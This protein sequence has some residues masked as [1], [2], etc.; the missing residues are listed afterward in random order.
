MKFQILSKVNY[1]LYSDIERTACVKKLLS[2]EETN[3][4]ICDNFENSS[5]QTQLEKLANYILYGKN[6]TTNTNL[7]QDKKIQIESKYKTF[8]KKKNESLDELLANP[9]FNEQSVQNLYTRNIYTKPRNPIIRPTYDKLGNEVD[10]GDGNIPTM[11]DL[12][13]SIDQMEHKIAIV[14]GDELPDKDEK[15]PQWSSLTLYKMKHWLIDLRKHQYY[16]RDAYCPQI[17][18]APSVM[19]NNPIDWNSN[20]G[21][22][23]K[24]TSPPQPTTTSTKKQLRL[25]SNGELEEYCMVSEHVLDFTN[26]NHVYHTLLEYNNLYKSN[27]ENVTSDM[28]SLLMLFEE[29]VKRTPLTLV[30]KKIVE[31]KVNHYTNEEICNILWREFGSKYNVNYISTVFKHNICEK[32]AVTA[33]QMRKEHDSQHDIS[34]WKKCSTCGKW[35]LRDATQFVRKKSSA[36]GLAARCKQCDKEIREGKNNE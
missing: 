30:Q 24:T 27:W 15:V 28:K 20:S 13:F 9:A 23:R 32:I 2:D 11:R 12:W 1:D 4:Y 25:N 16:V 29:I 3:C 26:A 7:V 5:T 22:W 34:K 18:V 14:T 33:S 8:T 6:K 19:E 31:L 17:V 21:Y 36:D 10:C 35:L